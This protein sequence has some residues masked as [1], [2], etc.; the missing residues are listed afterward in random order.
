MERLVLP[1]ENWRPAAAETKLCQLSRNLMPWEQKF[2]PQKSSNNI[3]TNCFFH[4]CCA[5][6]FLLLLFP[7][8]HYL[9]L[10]SMKNCEMTSVSWGEV[11]W[12]EMV[13][14]ENRLGAMQW[15]ELSWD[16]MRWDAV[17]WLEINEM[18]WDEVRQSEMRV[19]WG[20]II[21][22]GQEWFTVSWDMMTCE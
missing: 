15:G 14:G 22:N 16:E 19:R 11:T 4:L 17:G 7:L 6:S 10:W 20:E 9:T 21:W 18:R 8:Q 13:W 5:P 12:D 3:Q 2:L 1:T